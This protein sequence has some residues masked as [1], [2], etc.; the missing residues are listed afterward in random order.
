ME[1]G[2]QLPGTEDGNIIKKSR[3]GD[4][5]LDD[6]TNY[7]GFR[8][9]GNLL[10]TVT[11]SRHAPGTNIDG[12]PEDR[13][14]LG[15]PEV[16]SVFT[17]GTVT[18]NVGFFVELESNL[19]EDETGI[20]R[21][22]LT[23]NNLGQHD[24]AHLRIGKIDPSAYSSYS[25][26][27]Q[28]FELV[29]D[30]TVNNGSFMLPTINRI[31]LTPAAFASKFHGLFDRGGTA[32][33]STAPSLF[34]AVA[35]MGIDIHG[36]PFGDWFLY[37]V[38]ILNGANEP[39][40]DSN[41]AKDWYLLTRFDWAQSTYFSV[42]FSGFSY[43]GSNNAKVASRGDVSW[44]RY[45]FAANVRYYMVDFY[46]AFVV[47]RITD[48][49]ASLEGTF[50]TTATGF[51]FEANV[52]ATNRILVGLRLDH[53]DAGGIRNQRISNSLLALVAKY[54]LRSNIALFL[55]DDVNLRPSHGGRLPARNF[56]NAFFVGA[57][58]AF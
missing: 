34:H 55:R 40:G 6:V 24:W 54:Y 30:N 11:Y 10:R 26:L 35:E 47:D 5:T 44:S 46:A 27:R 31:G 15:F 36:R 9:R 39:F 13:T 28:Q 45:G 16:F 37:Q 50:D 43:F 3:L 7:L 14:E 53:L 4:L 12:N 2:Y 33:S 48:L 52:L 49:P 29:G 23:L 42:N 56:R 41:N 25:T 20:E 57:D 22:F 19:E 32:I 38:G 18:N 58:V 8:L 17:A 1:N 21:A 51:T